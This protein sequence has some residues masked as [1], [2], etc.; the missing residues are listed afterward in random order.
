[1]KELKVKG[2][3]V[4][5]RDDSII[6]IHYDDE[7]LSLETVKNVFYETRKVSPWEIAP[8]Y[9]TGGTFTNQEAEA[10]KFSASE[11]VMKY[12]SAIAFLSRTIGEKLMANF[13][14]KIMN[15]GKPTKFFTKEEE[16]IAWLKNYI[17]S[18]Q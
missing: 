1:M 3:H 17:V 13:F 14:I 8:V 10:R 6:H 12:C 16:A 2:A 9:L 11:E 7:L 4:K 5:F 18:K 15:P